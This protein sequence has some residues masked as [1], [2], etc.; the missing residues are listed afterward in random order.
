MGDRWLASASEQP[1]DRGNLGRALESVGAASRASP[2]PAGLHHAPLMVGKL[3]GVEHSR[4]RHLAA[5]HTWT[6]PGP[7]QA[8]RD[9][10]E[11]GQEIGVVD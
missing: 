3:Q 4:Q 10:Q 6:V 11:P 8:E 7:S 5:G 9:S 2:P 1:W